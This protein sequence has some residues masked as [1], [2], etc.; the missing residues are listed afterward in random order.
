[1]QTTRALQRPDALLD[2]LP[3]PTRKAIQNAY[4]TIEITDAIATIAGHQVSLVRGYTG[5]LQQAV[6]LASIAA[7]DKEAVGVVA[8]RQFDECFTFELPP[9]A[10]TVLLPQL[11]EDPDGTSNARAFFIAVQ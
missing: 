9:T 5:P 11:C 3:E 10:L 4:A 2:T 6:K 1:M 8:I 7:S